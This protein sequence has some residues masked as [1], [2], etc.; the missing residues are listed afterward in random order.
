MPDP[1]KQTLEIKAKLN[2][3]PLG[4]ASAANQNSKEV[5]VVAK[6]LSM[7][8]K[9]KPAAQ[10]DVLLSISKSNESSGIYKLNAEDYEEYSDD[11]GRGVRNDGNI[12]LNK[13]YP[14][15]NNK[16]KTRTDPLMITLEE[17]K[18]YYG[19]M[20]DI[21]SRQ[22]DLFEEDKSMGTSS[23]LIPGIEQRSYQE[24]NIPLTLTRSDMLQQKFAS[25]FTI[26]SNAPITSMP[27]APQRLN[28]VSEESELCI[29]EEVKEIKI[30]RKKLKRR[31]KQAKRQL[32][33]GSQPAYSQQQEPLEDPHE[34]FKRH[35]NAQLASVMQKVENI[36][37][38]ARGTT[39]ARLQRE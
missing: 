24:R 16:K 14:S 31:G 33:N 36:T 5:E 29:E 18:K 25:A 30:P 12:M 35:F 32:N 22:R 10:T 26:N 28:L 9:K 21:P 2:N 38:E 7:K 13:H 37:L 11:G 39:K 17:Q 34:A 4:A 15:T 27:G 1:A 8:D 6:S 23:I 3:I 20:K 19:H